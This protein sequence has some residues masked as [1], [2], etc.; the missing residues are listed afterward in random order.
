MTDWDLLPQAIGSHWRILSCLTEGRWRGVKKRQ[1][2]DYRR[3]VALG[4][5]SQSY[6][7]QEGI[8]GEGGSRGTQWGVWE[9]QALQSRV[10]GI[11]DRQC[12]TGIPDLSG[13]RHSAA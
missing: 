3:K 1:L 10:A 12:L 9:Q 6:G 5:W 7:T 13:L 11:G 8:V 4:A 2:Q